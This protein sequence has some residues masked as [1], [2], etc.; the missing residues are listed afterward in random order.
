MGWL[1][2]RSPDDPQGLREPFAVSRHGMA[3]STPLRSPLAMFL[4]GLG[5]LAG[6]LALLVWVWLTSLAQPGGMVVWQL[7]LLSLALLLVPLPVLWIGAVRLAWQRRY[8]RVT[9]SP[10]VLYRD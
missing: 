4:V 1:T 7:V 2:G 5:L 8:T 10:P 9:G 6:V 3:E